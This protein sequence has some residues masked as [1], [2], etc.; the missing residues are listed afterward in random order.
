MDEILDYMENMKEFI[1]RCNAKKFQ[2]NVHRDSKYLD[3]KIFKKYK[4]IKQKY[5]KT[6]EGINARKRGDEK[7]RERKKI[8]SSD[9]DWEQKQLIAEFY[10]NCPPGYEVDHIIPIGRGGKHILSNLQYLT[11]QEN[12]RK[13]NRTMEEF[14]EIKRSMNED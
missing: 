6:K 5:Y 4:K 3:N 12:R 9:L 10:A 7:R 14:Q 1:E 2:K 13:F 8:A 11:P